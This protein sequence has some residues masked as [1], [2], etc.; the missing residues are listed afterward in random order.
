M[1][2][3]FYLFHTLYLINIIE[4]NT[5]L[6]LYTKS[7]KRK[8]SSII[9]NTLNNINYIEN[10]NDKVSYITSFKSEDGVIYITTNTENSNSEK[11]L[12]YII[13]TNEI[14]YF[15]EY[16]ILTMA[17]T[18]HNKYA[19]ITLLK[20]DNKEY[21]VSLSHEGQFELF[22]YENKIAYYC[23]FFKVLSQNSVIG[24]NTFTS[25]KYYNN[26]NYV[27]N[28]Y[29]DKHDFY[30]LIQKLYYKKNNINQNGNIETTQIKFAK[31][32]KSS[33]VTCFEIDNLV[34]CLFTNEDLLYTISIF[35]I[36]DLNS[37]YNETIETSPVDTDE[38]FSKCIYIKNNV[39]AFIYFISN[40]HFPKIKF[41]K[42]IIND[43]D[44]ILNDYGESININSQDIFPLGYSYIYNDIIKIDDNNIFYIST[45]NDSTEIYLILIK[46]LNNDNN[47]LINYYLLKLNEVYNI[48][49]YKDITTFSLNG[50]LGI[51]ITNYDYGLDN[52]KTYSS[53]FL[54][55]NYSF[56]NN[57]NISSNALFFNEENGIIINKIINIE[58]N[59]FGYF[60]GI[61]ILSFIDEINI[62]F[63]LYSNMQNKNININDSFYFDD[64]IIFKT[65]SIT[66]VKL[67]NYSIEY[68]VIIEEQEELVKFNSYSSY[69]EYFPNNEND[70]KLIYQPKIF[71]EKK[72]FLN[73][74][75]NKCYDTCEK[76][77]YLGDTTNHHC[78][79]CSENYPF[80]F[81]TSTGKN[82]FNSCPDKYS[83]DENKKC[84]ISTQINNC[85]KL[86]Y[87]DS[88]LKINCI[89]GDICIDE[90]PHLDE[91][92]KN[93][94]TNCLVKY[95]NKCYLECP[96]NTCIKQDKNLNECIDIENNMKVINNI[97]FEN[98]TDIVNDLKNMSN[99]NIV[100]ENIP[101]LKV[102]AYDINKDS[103]YYI[104]NKLTYIYFENIK[105]IIIQNY[106]LD[107]D[108]NIYTLLV[109]SPSK[110][111]N[112]STNDFDFVLLLENGTELNLSNIH[113]DLKVNI[114][115]P[116]TNLDLVN[117][118]YALELSEQGY[119]I[120][121]ENSS[122][123]HDICTPGYIDDNDIILE[124]RKKEFYPNN[125][126][127]RKSNCIYQLADLINQRFVYECNISNDN[128]ITNEVNSFEI[129]EKENNF[130]NYI[131]DFINYKVLNCS[132]LFSDLNNYRHNKAV[133]ISTTCTFMSFLLFFIF[134]FHGL[135]KIRILVHNEIPTPYKIKKIIMQYKE[136]I[137]NIKYKKLSVFSSNP[138][139][140]NKKQIVIKHKSFSISKRNFL[141]NSIDNIQDSNS[142]MKPI[143]NDNKNKSNNNKRN[144][145]SI[146]KNNIIKSNKRKNS[147][148][149]KDSINNNVIDNNIDNDI[150]DD[151]EYDDL[152]L[153]L[154][155]RKD[156][157]SIVKIFLI[158]IIEKI[159]ILDIFVN[160]KIKEILLSK[161]ILFLLLNLS[162]NA[163]LYSDQIVSQKRHN[164]GKLDFLVSIVLSSMSNII[165]SIID[166]Y[167]QHLIGFEERMDNIKEIKNEIIFLKVFQIIYREIIIRVII[168]LIIEILIIIFCSYYLFIFFTIYHKS[169]MSML[170]NYCISLLENWL[171]NLIIT[172]IIVIL[173]K[174]GIHFN[175]KYIYNTSKF[176]DKNF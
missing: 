160:K 94:C 114:S 168:F 46:L 95:N 59:I 19:L 101:N 80:Y 169:Q 135:S 120:Y 115:F 117:Y 147:K 88:D 142:K 104:K 162:M 39:G 90:Y 146:T 28:V 58:N 164:N 52:N 34:E 5:N 99:N 171:I 129:E 121:N 14:N 45:T 32:F 71:F 79:T 51:G 82:C 175:S 141:I 38:L 31:A 161:Y 87:I 84:I 127:T 128:N 7:K 50:L 2:I 55:G 1:N 126:T 107:K 151:I 173:R 26:C 35:N 10:I 11:R 102:Y 137:K 41:K 18:T 167:L 49:I 20:I 16:K 96:I 48:K 44:Y 113:E 42:L 119:D 157:R 100:I 63:Y 4:V 77:S 43:N 122:F 150:D 66:G 86:Y 22:D 166:Y 23:S 130:I 3:I 6:I 136:K 170:G 53:F 29:V 68:S 124:E 131:L 70:F 149:I 148:I 110:Y 176:F 13:R 30:F 158:K 93:L 15:Y 116:I 125:A 56:N 92:I 111:S 64:I 8:L 154:A 105:D 109:S 17:S 112:S 78:E 106:N 74:H 67:G 9:D 89:N 37:I 69:T 132:I 33:S 47:I 134:I 165:A 54:L 12:I 138:I 73:I 27:L 65:N 118:D 144:T 98:F 152:P 103:D 83:P 91:S 123:Y 61:K 153:S 24:K 159:D 139:K 156:K 174:I 72:S 163:L 140:R 133:M 108:T 40:N 25:L 36:S 57:F 145:I 75:I 21:I 143:I 97:C 62:G 60:I 85:H 76:C 81:I 155:L 172:I